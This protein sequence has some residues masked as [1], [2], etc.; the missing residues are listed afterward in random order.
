MSAPFLAT[1]IM[2]DKKKG[3]WTSL[4]DRSNAIEA[5]LDRGDDAQR[6]VLRRAAI[7]EAGKT[8]L[9]VSLTDS[10]RVGEGEFT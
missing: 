9:P 6:T 2:R 7:D 10:R 8:R 5:E 1:I 4:D 3:S